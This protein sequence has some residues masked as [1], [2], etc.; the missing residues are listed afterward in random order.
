M[1]HRNGMR[2]RRSHRMLGARVVYDQSDRCLCSSRGLSARLRDRPAAAAGCRIKTAA[3]AAARYFF[4]AVSSMR[5]I[6]LPMASGS[7]N[8]PWTT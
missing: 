2:A 6:A 1:L 3:R 8:S 4:L 7:T 5:M